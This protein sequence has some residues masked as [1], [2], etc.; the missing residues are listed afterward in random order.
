MSFV[1][2][3]SEDGERIQLSLRDGKAQ[4]SFQRDDH[5]LCSVS[6]HLFTN[7]ERTPKTVLMV[8]CD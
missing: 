8:Y 4:S 1:S 5:Q 7:T 3:V 2:L 6:A